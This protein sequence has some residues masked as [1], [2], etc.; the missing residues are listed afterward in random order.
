MLY[1][2]LISFC[3]LTSPFFCHSLGQGRTK[4]RNCRLTHK[5]SD[6]QVGWAIL[7]ECKQ[8]DTHK[9]NFQF[10]YGKFSQPYLL[11][12]IT[13]RVHYINGQY[14]VPPLRSSFLCRIVYTIS[15]CKRE[16]ISWLDTVAT[17][18]VVLSGGP[19]SVDGV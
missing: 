6:Y 11:C 4:S 8:L 12:Y 16:D 3:L 18:E 9:H 10:M 14:T 17:K 13:L 1:I 2:F 5:T 7:A 19:P 15:I